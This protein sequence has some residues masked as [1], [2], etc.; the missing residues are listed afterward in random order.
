MEPDCSIFKSL[1]QPLEF[2]ARGGEPVSIQTLYFVEFG[3]YTH[4]GARGRDALIRHFFRTS[5]QQCPVLEG[6]RFDWFKRDSPRST[7]NLA[8]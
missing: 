5:F 7:E 1:E 3:L 2:G 4:F 6:K 8:P